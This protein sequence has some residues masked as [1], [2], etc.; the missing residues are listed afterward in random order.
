MTITGMGVLNTVGTCSVASDINDRV[1]GQRIVTPTNTPSQIR[2]TTSTMSKAATS[3]YI[4]GVSHLPQSGLKGRIDTFVTK[5]GNSRFIKPIIDKAFKKQQHA[6]TAQADEIA[7]TANESKATTDSIEKNTIS[8]GTAFTNVNDVQTGMGNTDEMDL[9]DPE[10]LND[11]TLG[12]DNTHQLR[13]KINRD[14]LDQNIATTK[15]FE[16]ITGPNKV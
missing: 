3:T 15:D 16:D 11:L 8:E 12:G 7:N 10:N 4:P 2:A 13:P 5:L 6:L 9:F 1:L 14:T